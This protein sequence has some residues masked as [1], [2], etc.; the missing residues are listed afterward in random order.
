MSADGAAWFLINVSP[1]LSRQ[2]A[3]FP[4]L[5]ARPDLGR[6]SPIVG[7]LLTNADLDHT[8]GLPLLRESPALAVHATPAVRESV[9]AAGIAGLL[10]AFCETGWH[11][12]PDEFAP[13]TTGEGRPSGLEY[14]FIGL[15]GGPPRFF[16]KSAYDK[17]HSGAYVIADFTNRRAPPDRAGRGG[18]YPRTVRTPSRR[19]TSSF[20]M[21]RSGPATSSCSTGPARAWRRRWDIYPSGRAASMR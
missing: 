21:V 1:D 2:I 7:V 19:L 12:P 9:E 16:Q 14:R 6:N 17:G 8:Y 18:D 13:L 15:P 11:E 20:S 10:G 4:A 3:A 5:H